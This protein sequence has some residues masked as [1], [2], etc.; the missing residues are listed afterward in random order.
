MKHFLVGNLNEIQVGQRKV[1]SCDGTEVGVFNVGGELVAWYNNCPHMRGPVCQGR[2]FE[3]VLEP[4]AEDGT[5]RMMEF[6]ENHTHVVCPWHGFEFDLRTGEHPGSARHRLRKA[7][8]K[9]DSGEIYV[10]I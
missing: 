5:V 4:V 9:I 8:L 6:S 1:V 3:R 7:E 10:V 2:I